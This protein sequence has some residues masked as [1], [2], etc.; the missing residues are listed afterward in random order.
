M[1]KLAPLSLHP[2]D[3]PPIERAVLRTECPSTY[4]AARAAVED[5]LVVLRAY[6]YVSQE[7]EETYA[8]LCLDEA[9][10]NA[11]RHGNRLRAE[12]RCRLAVFETDSGW[13]AR[14]EDEGG[15]FDPSMLPDPLQNV[16]SDHGRGIFLIRCFM[17]RVAFFRGG[18]TIEMEKNKR[19]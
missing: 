19:V 1:A 9:L 16:E 15:G 8:R 13:G 5:A 7:Q 11:V 18:R 17:D 4:E 3:P 2:G 14:V 6:G 10:S 12:K